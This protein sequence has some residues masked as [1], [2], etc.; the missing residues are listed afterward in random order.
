[1]L[2]TQNPFNLVTI[3]FRRVELLIHG[4]LP[5]PRGH[6]ATSYS[7]LRQ[8]WR[9]HYDTYETVLQSAYFGSMLFVSTSLM[10]KKSFHKYNR[11]AMCTEMP[12]RYGSG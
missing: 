2:N 8:I 1:M 11:W 6:V 4:H 5:Q 3:K 10:R 9:K 12:W 7:K